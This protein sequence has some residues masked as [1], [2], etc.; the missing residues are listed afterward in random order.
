MYRG[1][2]VQYE[3]IRI[4]TEIFMNRVRTAKY[5]SPECR[6]LAKAFIRPAGEAQ[7]GG[8]G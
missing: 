6:L 3:C 2:T 7:T 8:G 1:N 5:C 4:S